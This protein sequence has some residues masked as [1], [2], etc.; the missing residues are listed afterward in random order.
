MTWP[1]GFWLDLAWWPWL[2]LAALAWPGLVALAWPW[3]GLA[4]AW[5]GLVWPL[6]GLG[7]RVYEGLCMYLNP[8]APRLLMLCYSSPSSPPPQP[9]PLPLHTAHLHRT[10]TLYPLHHRVTEA[11]PTYCPA[12]WSAPPP[13]RA[14]TAGGTHKNTARPAGGGGD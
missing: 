4:L 9:P 12:Y 2:G 5:P 7:G 3:L 10:L 13:P 14:K 1:G 11:L 8:C 6:F